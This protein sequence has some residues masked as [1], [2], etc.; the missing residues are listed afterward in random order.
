LLSEPDKRNIRLCCKQL[1]LDI[2]TLVG[3]NVQLVDENPIES[4][5]LLEWIQ[6]LRINEIDVCAENMT[7]RELI[8]LLQNRA[9]LQSVNI[10]DPNDFDLIPVLTMLSGMDILQELYINHACKNYLGFLPI[11]I[12]VYRFSRLQTL[13]ISLT[14]GPEEIS[15]GTAHFF[16]DV[17]CPQLQDLSLS[18]CLDPNSE[19]IVVDQEECLNYFQWLLDMIEIF[20]SIWGLSVELQLYSFRP[21]YGSEYLIGT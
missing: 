21:D 1:R 16:L 9:C 5:E 13:Y 14:V 6:S 2:D 18:V 20:P 4:D 12:S 11:P 19:S 10:Q 15:L 3:L 8:V 17:C 7:T